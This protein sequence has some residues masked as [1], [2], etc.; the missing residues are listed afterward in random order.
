MLHVVCCR[1]PLG[2]LLAVPISISSIKWKWVVQ[3]EVCIL[4]WLQPDSLISVDRQGNVFQWGPTRTISALAWHLPIKSWKLPTHVALICP[5]SLTDGSGKH[6]HWFNLP[7][8]KLNMPTLHHC[9]TCKL[10]AAL[11]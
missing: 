3:A 5:R 8:C 9:C 6:V 1:E 11:G 10:H 2:Y 4:G 7:A